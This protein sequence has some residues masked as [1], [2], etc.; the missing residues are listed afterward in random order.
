MRNDIEWDEIRADFEDG[1][2]IRSL[3]RKYSVSKTAIINRR[4]KEQWTAKPRGPKE[5]HPKEDTN[6]DVKAVK[7]LQLY[8]E[9]GMTYD[10]IAK[11]IG[12]YDRSVARR[13]VRREIAKA[14]PEERKLE[15]IEN[16]IVMSNQLL[17]RLFKTGMDKTDKHWMFAVDRYVALVRHIASLH[18]LDDKGNEFAN[19]III[20]DIPGE[21]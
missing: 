19:Q 13:A 16:D 6:A 9:E 10:Q 14:L 12:Y 18:G 11:T 1:V 17:A 5:Y 20:Q 8:L 3:E 4:N 2:S 21:V 7:A 15:L